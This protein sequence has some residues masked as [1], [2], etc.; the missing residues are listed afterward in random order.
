MK[1]LLRQE[2]N[3]HLAR[4]TS[5]YSDIS[6]LEQTVLKH[7]YDSGKDPDPKYF[8]DTTK[9]VSLGYMNSPL[10]NG[11][12]KY[13]IFGIM[14]EHME[15]FKEAFYEEEYAK[16]TLGPVLNYWRKNKI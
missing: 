3:N 13:F 1:V 8:N 2:F 16:D 10:G 5:D 11:N 7:L 6:Q 12:K 14:D 4:L 15:I 9:Y